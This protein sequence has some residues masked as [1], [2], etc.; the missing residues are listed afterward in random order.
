MQTTAMSLDELKRINQLAESTRSLTYLNEV[1]ERQRKRMEHRSDWFL[2]PMMP[3]KLIDYH[4]MDAVLMMSG[5]G[6][7]TG[8]GGGAGAA[9]QTSGV[10]V[11][12]RRSWRRHYQRPRSGEDPGLEPPSPPTGSTPSPSGAAVMSGIPETDADAGLSLDDDED[13][14]YGDGFSSTERSGGPQLIIHF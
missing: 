9:N 13:E 5:G 11:V 8:S 1:H 12:R 7:G 3:A 6:T 10:A 2:S 14:S 4:S